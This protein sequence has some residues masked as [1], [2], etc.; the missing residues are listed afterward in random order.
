MRA[1]LASP[2]GFLIGL[3]LGALGGGGS[4]LAV[5]VLVYVAG[6]GAKAATTTSL[7]VVGAIS[8]G[9][10][11]AHWRAGR[12][13]GGAGLVFGFAGVGGSLVGS[14]LNRRVNPQVLLLGFAALMVVAAWRML[15]SQKA[16][17]GTPASD[18]D[19]LP[20]HAQA[21]VGAGALV[22]APASHR[23][24]SGTSGLAGSDGPVTVGGQPKSGVASQSFIQTAVRVVVVGT[25][26]G[27]MTGFFGV[28][29]G[30]VV[31]PGLVLALRF[32]MPVAVGTSLLVIVVNT[33]V[34]LA[35]RL[36][37]TGIPWGVAIPFTVSGLLGVALGNRLASKVSGPVLVRWFAALLVALAAY[38]AIRSGMALA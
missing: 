4:I 5:P 18:P 38:T 16:K 27:F 3:S 23:S 21:N 14:A 20:I 9:G 25:V 29:G 11:I 7:V 28:G 17:K 31:V 8:F 13:K 34:A 24:L 37:T 1:L 15:A 26:V 2:L 12:V 36:A 35:S 22:A 32:D 33:I 19:D 30:F 6:Q 10:M